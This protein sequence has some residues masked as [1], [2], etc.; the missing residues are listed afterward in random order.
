MTRVEEPPFHQSF[1]FHV[2]FPPLSTSLRRMPHAGSPVGLNKY[3]HR[4][5]GLAR[6]VRSHSKFQAHIITQESE[7][8]SGSPMHGS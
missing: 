6:I 1:A 5:M 2:S 4:S 3:D 8:C 7:V